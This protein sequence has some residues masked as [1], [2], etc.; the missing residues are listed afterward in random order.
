MD[1]KFIQTTSD[2]LDTLQ[3]VDGQ[4]VA[5]SD[6]AG[7]YYDLNGERRNGSTYNLP[8]ANASRLGGVKLSDL[9]TSNGG[10]ASSGV[11]ASSYAV[12]QAYTDLNSKLS[13]Y[14]PISDFNAA[15][16]SASWLPSNGFDLLTLTAR[17]W[18][19]S[20]NSNLIAAQG[21]PTGF[22]A[23]GTYFGFNT[24]TYNVI[25]YLDVFGLFATYATHTKN[26]LPLATQGSVDSI[27][28]SLNGKLDS[29]ALS[30]ISTSFRASINGAN[31]DILLY[32][33][34]RIVNISATCAGSF[35]STYGTSGAI[36]PQA[37]R[38]MYSQFV[39][40]KNTTAANRSEQF[41]NCSYIIW[42][43]GQV[44][45]TADCP[46]LTLARHFSATWI[47]Y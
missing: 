41:G 19:Y 9:Y 8:T 35:S 37:Y 27:S 3:I 29:S 39:T 16:A 43:S 25:C 33:Y 34:G 15:L 1:V 17:A 26:W 2:K 11:A 45:V 20:A 32:K 47:T 18:A 12:Y 23:Y 46:S 6:I 38:P 44:E 4:I 28:T 30:C 5:L 14:L 10:A 13:K 31:F 36:I 22:S 42:S 21:I 24:A 40:I 7:L